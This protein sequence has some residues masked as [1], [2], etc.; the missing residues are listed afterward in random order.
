M[1]FCLY[2]LKVRIIGMYHHT[3]L[4]SAGNGNQAFVRARQAHHQLTYYT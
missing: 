4:S 1:N 2:L 3:R